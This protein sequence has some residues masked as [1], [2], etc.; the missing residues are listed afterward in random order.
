MK[1]E[2]VDKGKERNHS[3]AF[4]VEREILAGWIKIKEIKKQIKIP[5]DL[6]VGEKSVILLAQEQGAQ[7][8][9]RRNLRAWRRK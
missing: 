8:Y 1:E 7:S 3:D 2:V 6:D 5:F 4:L 9:S